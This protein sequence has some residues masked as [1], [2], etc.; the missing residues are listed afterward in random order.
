MA[1]R[2]LNPGG[3]LDRYVAGLYVA[4]W[5][6]AFLC[7][8]GLYLVLDMATKLDDYVEPFADGRPMGAVRI[9][10]LYA[11]ELPFKFLEIGPFVSLVA[12]L[13]T[14]GR[15]LRNNE[16]IAALGAG[17]S[18]QRLLAPVLVLG[19]L[20]GGASFFL[21][22]VLS[23]TIAAKRDAVRYVVEEKR[24]DQSYDH[25]WIKD[26]KGGRIQ[27][28][29][30]RPSGASGAPEVEGL[31]ATLA[32]PAHLVTVTA[33]RAVWTADASG[34]HWR[35]E[36]GERRDVQTVGGAQ[37]IE[38]VERLDGFEASPS[39]ALSYWRANN[40]PLELSF[41]EAKELA[42][43]DPDNVVYRTLLQH[44]VTFPLANLVL[45]LVGLPLLLRHDRRRGPEGLAAGG[46]LCVFYFA[47]DFVLRNLG[48]QGSL[49]PVLAAWLP[50]LFFGSLGIVLFDG[51]KT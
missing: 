35:L 25:L 18:A 27:F 11:L 45:L 22:E 28:V 41:A 2:F 23:S 19:A 37:T 51:M 14:V 34:G 6:T 32:T 47:A 5:A 12:G 8:V 44:H 17:V 39:L 29:R 15:L 26:K 49:D 40:A 13:F 10:T 31:E 1:L 46:I 50:V 4:S 24:L 21:R 42:R 3:K 20:A 33:T 36:N 9:V 43:R 30:F 7:V 16:T 48:L 38:K